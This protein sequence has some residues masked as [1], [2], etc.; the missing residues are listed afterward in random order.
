MKL[1]VSLML[2]RTQASVHL[3]MI[4]SNIN[5]HGSTHYIQYT[6]KLKSLVV[7]D[8]GELRSGLG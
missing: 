1:L 6:I 2:A 5:R 3:P 7:V 8:L 4:A